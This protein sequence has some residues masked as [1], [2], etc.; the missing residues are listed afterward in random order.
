MNECRWCGETHL[1]G[2]C[3]KV[4]AIEFA[5]DGTT[6]RRVEFLA[7]TD[8][9]LINWQIASPPWPTIPQQPVPISIPTPFWDQGF[10]FTA[11]TQGPTQ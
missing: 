6:V 1:K 4:K 11:N 3:P 2:I 8:Y 10:R 9:H 5:D 7:P